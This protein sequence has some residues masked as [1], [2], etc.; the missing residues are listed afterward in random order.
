MENRIRAFFE[1]NMELPPDGRGGGDP[2]EGRGGPAETDEVAEAEA[3]HQLH[4]AACA[5]LLE[6]AYADEQFTEDERLHI[7]AVLRRHFG[8]GEDQARQLIELADAERS[9]GGDPFHFARLIRSSYDQGQKALLAE[10]MWGLILAD[11]RIARH[12]AHLLQRIAGLLGL[13]RGYLSEARRP[14]SED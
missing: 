3:R 4:L 8:L 5:L 12:E 10:V 14:A 2:G 7:E 9:S 6:L 1:R 13:E 11:G